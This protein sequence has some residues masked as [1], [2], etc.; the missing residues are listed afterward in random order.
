MAFQSEHRQGVPNSPISL[1]LAPPLLP[2]P[3]LPNWALGTSWIFSSIVGCNTQGHRSGQPGGV[4][5]F[6]WGSH[7]LSGFSKTGGPSGWA[8]SP[9]KQ[10]HGAFSLPTRHSSPPPNTYLGDLK[11][12]GGVQHPTILCCLHSVPATLLHPLDACERKKVPPSLSC[13]WLRSRASSESPPSL[14]VCPTAALEWNLRAASSQATC[15]I[16]AN[17]HT[18]EVALQLSIA[19]PEKRLSGLRPRGWRF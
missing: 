18:D 2:F 1:A 19:D 9:G 14:S 4:G 5:G 17:T 6:L 15:V 3:Q 10:E 8:R 7:C 16:S 12:F 11:E 13:W